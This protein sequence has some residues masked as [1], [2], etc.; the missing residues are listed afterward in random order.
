MKKTVAVLLVV[1]LA[2]ICFGCSKAPTQLGEADVTDNTTVA[3][4]ETTS[5]TQE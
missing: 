2:L 3:E 5:V 1:A 4:V